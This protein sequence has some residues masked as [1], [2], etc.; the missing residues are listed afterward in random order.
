MKTPVPESIFNKVAGLVKI[1]NKY[2]GLLRNNTLLEK[3]PNTKFFLV[4]IFL[5]S[6]R[7]QGNT[8]QKKIRIRT[9]F[10]Q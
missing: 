10:T 6:D 1:L 9:L 5:Y 7:M 4:R 3:Y 2:K 8:D